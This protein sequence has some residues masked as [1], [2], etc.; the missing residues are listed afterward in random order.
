LCENEERY[1]T[2]VENVGDHAIFMLDAD[3]RVTEWT[4]SA[5]RVKG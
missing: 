5:E 4:R 3:G 1:R 2:L